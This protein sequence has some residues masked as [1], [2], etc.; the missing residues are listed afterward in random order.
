MASAKSEPTGAVWGGASS[1]VQEHMRSPWSVVRESGGETL[2]S[3]RIKAQNCDFNTPR[4][5][6]LQVFKLISRENRCP[7]IHAYGH[8]VAI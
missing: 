5:V 8:C 1:G 7:L 2:W 6:V 3:R 4:P